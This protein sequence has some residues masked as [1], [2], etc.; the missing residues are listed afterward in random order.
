M[1]TSDG[2]FLPAFSL[3]LCC[4]VMLPL[5]C[6]PFMQPCCTVWSSAPF[7]CGLLYWSCAILRCAPRLSLSVRIKINEIEIKINRMLTSMK[8]YVL[9][10]R[11]TA[12]RVT[13]ARSLVVPA[14]RLRTINI[15]R[16]PTL[17]LQLTLLRVPILS[18]SVAVTST[19][20]ILLSLY[21]PAPSTLHFAGANRRSTSSITLHLC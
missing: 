18:V 13:L 14:T 20:L 4:R 19:Q 1:W 3:H 8:L 17:I 12:R 15:N 10:S 21:I 6:L 16:M 5:P 9:Y 7:T 11:A 2:V